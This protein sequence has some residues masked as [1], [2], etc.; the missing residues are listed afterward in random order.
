VSPVLSPEVLAQKLTG[1]VE[2]TVDI[3]AEGKVEEVILVD[4]SSNLLESSAIDAAWRFRYRPKRDENY[5]PIA[6]SGVKL[7]ISF[8]YSLLARSSGCG[9]E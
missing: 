5:L 9:L 1:W 4:S 2:L 3:D 7:T 8:D 6:E